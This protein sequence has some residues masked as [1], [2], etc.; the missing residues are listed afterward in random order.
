M[1]SS[2]F[3]LQNLPCFSAFFNSCE[4]ISAGNVVSRARG[5][6]QMGDEFKKENQ[7]TESVGPTRA[8]RTVSALGGI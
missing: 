8:A 4:N 3:Y 7:K 1:P 2:A 6:G 5:H